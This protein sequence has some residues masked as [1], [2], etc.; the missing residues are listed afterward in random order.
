MTDNIDLAVQAR[1]QSST[2]KNKSLHC[3]HTFAVKRRVPV[4]GNLE[5]TVPQ[6]NVED[7]EMVEILPGPEVQESVKSSL[8]PLVLRILT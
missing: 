6:K 5:R 4:D 1:H 8:V 2:H 3:T 7:L